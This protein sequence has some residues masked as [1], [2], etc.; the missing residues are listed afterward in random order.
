MKCQFGFTPHAD[1][2]NCYGTGA[3]SLHEDGSPDEMCAFC[4]ED[5]IR[6]GELDGVIGGLTYVAGTV[7]SRAFPTHDPRWHSLTPAQQAV[8]MRGWMEIQVRT[9]HWVDYTTP[10]SVAAGLI[11][12][13]L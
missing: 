6:S 4:L 12:D 2:D 3:F 13:V 7:V 1:C 9:S 10:Q 11:D 5:G 8:V